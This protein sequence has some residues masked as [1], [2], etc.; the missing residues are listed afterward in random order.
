MA[1][2]VPD[3]P[4]VAY[5]QTLATQSKEK[6]EDTK[7]ETTE[8]TEKTKEDTKDE[9]TTESEHPSKQ[10]EIVNTPTSPS[11]KKPLPPVITAVDP[12]TVI[13][14]PPVS[15]LKRPKPKPSTSRT[16]V[17]ASSYYPDEIIVAIDNQ[18]YFEIKKSFFNTLIRLARK[19]PE[20]R[21]YHRMECYNVE[22]EREY[23]ESDKD[24]VRWVNKWLDKC[25]R[26]YEYEYWTYHK[27]PP[28]YID[29]LVRGKC[30]REKNLHPDDRYVKDKDPYY[31]GRRRT[32]MR[33]YQRHIYNAQGVFNLEVKK[34]PAE[35][36]FD[37]RLVGMHWLMGFPLVQTLTADSNKGVIYMA[38]LT[39]RSLRLCFFPGKDVKIYATTSHIFSV[40]AFKAYEFT[41]ERSYDEDTVHT[42]TYYWV[43]SQDYNVAATKPY[44]IDRRDIRN[45]YYGYGTVVIVS[46]KLRRQLANDTIPPECYKAEK[47]CIKLITKFKK[48]I[49]ATMTDGE[50]E[51][52]TRSGNLRYLSDSERHDNSIIEKQTKK[53]D[54]DL[55]KK[56]KKYKDQ[57]LTK[58]HVDEAVPDKFRIKASTVPEECESKDDKDGK[59]KAG[60][61]KKKKDDSDSLDRLKFI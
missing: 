47:K 12:V 9:E 41:V 29:C 22:K 59:K 35:Y 17:A 11:S 26:R 27:K 21:K 53:I 42:L 52:W 19:F 58:K 6:S 38:N 2:N 18:R 32:R 45:F 28:M 49:K 24:N 10:V 4:A 1:S 16:V 20:A 50:L 33:K 23:I 14:T 55:K 48:R 56:Y 44:S 31:L 36:H 54:E 7:D 61:R 3:D 34:M 37:I 15:P 5:A 43:D 60:E 30:L 46:P 8:K 13:N 57:H 25:L 39:W 51:R 40:Y